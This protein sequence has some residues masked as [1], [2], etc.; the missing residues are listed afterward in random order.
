MAAMI[1]AGAVPQIESTY[2]GQSP[3][4]QADANALAA[5]GAATYRGGISNI[6]NPAGL[7]RAEAFRLDFGV[8]A[9]HH[10]EDRFMPVYDSFDNLVTDMAIASNQNTWWNGGFALAGRLKNEP[11]PLAFGLSLADRYP[12]SYRFDEELRD[13]S[14]FSSPRDVILEE[15][16]YEVTGSVKNLSLGLATEI[17]DRIAVGV[18]VHAAIG[19]RNE[20]WSV[21][22]N[23]LDD[24]N[25]SYENG[26]EWG[27]GGVNATFGLQGRISNRLTLGLAYETAMTAEGDY[28]T[29][30]FDY[31]DEEPTTFKKLESI[32]YPAYW[33]G[34]LAFFPRSDPRT[35]FTA[36]V[37]YSDWTK[38][39]D[40]RWGDEKPFLQDVV[41]VRI[42]VEHTFYSQMSLR[43][44]FR[45]Y[46]SYADDEGGNSVFSVGGG[47]PVLAGEL[48]L[49]LE[50]NKLQSYEPHI[51]GY[52]E[53]YVA[54]DEARV[55]D[56]RTRVGIGWS[57]EF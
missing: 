51:F 16:V 26:T 20:H 53:G 45:R 17:A 29:S 55:D 21:R 50:I 41:D 32:K 5:T 56:R 34:G 8:G 13:P 4:Y 6:F 48:S 9:S 54:D 28:E 14:P 36:D 42:G 2:G 23:D 3:W 19:Y 10:E 39:V 33:R 7:V 12:F 24:G 25:Q 44:G 47:F 49:S 1:P 11:I 18:A 35:V 43:F 31:G 27:L 38:L 30:T 37:V 15:R 46:D 57:R 40:T 22:D 52:P